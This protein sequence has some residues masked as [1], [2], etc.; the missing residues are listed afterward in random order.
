M[1]LKAFFILGQNFSNPLE[2]W[3]HLLDIYGT[4]YCPIL[5]LSE[6]NENTIA[7]VKSIYSGTKDSDLLHVLLCNKTM[8]LL[9]I[10]SEVSPI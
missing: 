1:N 4:F 8:K 5:S 2:A 9:L 6:Y 3:E 7:R 10:E